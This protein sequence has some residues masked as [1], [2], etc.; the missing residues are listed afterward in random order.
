VVIDPLKG[1][2]SGIGGSGNAGE[3]AELVGATK[4]RHA[5]SVMVDKGKRRSGRETVKLAETWRA[6]RGE[7][8]RFGGGEQL[9]GATRNASASH[10]G[11]ATWGRRR[12]NAIVARLEWNEVRL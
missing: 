7:D 4:R 5:A 2:Q 9:E 1:S 3:D 6:E 11:Q 8:N 10:C 12:Q